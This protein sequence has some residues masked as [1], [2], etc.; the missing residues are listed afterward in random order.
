MSAGPAQARNRNNVNARRRVRE[1]LRL[2]EDNCMQV[3]EGWQWVQECT[4]TRQVPAVQY[5]SVRPDSRRE[6]IESFLAGKVLTNWSNLWRDQSCDQQTFLQVRLCQPGR[7]SDRRGQAHR[8]QS[9]ICFSV[10]LMVAGSACRSAGI[11]IGIRKSLAR[12]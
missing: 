8:N 9:D 10:L 4:D 7:H 1:D 5:Y 2:D 12:T 3:R 11:C 6:T